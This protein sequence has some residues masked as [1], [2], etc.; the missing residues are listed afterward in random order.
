MFSILKI[1]IFRFATKN[2][3]AKYGSL[4]EH[5]DLGKETVNVA[6]LTMM[7]HVVGDCKRQDTLMQLPI[8]KS[9][10][11]IWVENAVREQVQV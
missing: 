2:I 4:L 11:E 8:L 1:F 9:F 6:V 10:S 7:Y 5:Q 3:M